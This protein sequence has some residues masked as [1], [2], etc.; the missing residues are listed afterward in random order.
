[1]ESLSAIGGDH[2][3]KSEQ[4]GNSASLSPV[5]GAHLT[6]GLS[7]SPRFRG[8]PRTYPVVVDVLSA[9]PTPYWLIGIISLLIVAWL[10]RERHE[11]HS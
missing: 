9:P 1:M 8:D 2:V 4:L 11:P 7:A 3:F 6:G 5:D 10:G